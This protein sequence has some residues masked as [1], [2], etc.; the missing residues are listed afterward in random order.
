MDNDMSYWESIYATL[1]P[2]LPLMP[3]SQTTT[4]SE[5]TAWEYH[6]GSVLLDPLIADRV[7]DCS[8]KHKADPIH[9]FLAAF[10][11]LLTCHSGDTDFSIGLSE[12]NRESLDDLATLGFLIN[13]LPLRLK[14]TIESTFAEIIDEAKSQVRGALMQSKVP[15]D[16]LLQR[17]N[18]PRA[19][20]HAPLF[21]AA[22]DYRQGWYM[23]GLAI[24]DCLADDMSAGQSQSVD[25]G[26][27]KFKDLVMS[28]SRNANDI[29]LEVVKP[30]TGKTKIT[31]KLQ[32]SIYAEED[33]MPLLKSYSEGRR[34]QRSDLKPWH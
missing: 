10:Q 18:I 12:M 34:Y 6:E 25:F 32:T 30:P 13:L 19:S 21:Q 17:L 20:T 31:L 26:T 24:D 23:T 22:F 14:C 28:R 5:A 16:V 2:V 3:L 27:A 1:P 15:F 4:R 11:T 9:F 29:A 33:V 8:R 7:R